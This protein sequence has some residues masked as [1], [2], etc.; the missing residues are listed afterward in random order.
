LVDRLHSPIRNSF[1]VKKLC[2]LA[3][4]ADTKLSVFDSVKIMYS[5]V[6][7]Y[8]SL[9]DGGIITVSGVKE[10]CDIIGNPALLEAQSLGEQV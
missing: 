3:V 8:F 6:L 5:L 2:L 7:K 1:K 4:S 10:K 9:E